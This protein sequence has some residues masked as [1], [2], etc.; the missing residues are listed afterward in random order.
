VST[1]F[2][3]G[4]HNLNIEKIDDNLIKSEIC[5]DILRSLP[6]WFGIEEAIKEYVDGVCDKDFFVAENNGEHIG[7]FAIDYPHKNVANL[8][9]LGINEEYHRKGMGTMLYSHVEDY[10]KS[11]GYSYISVYTLSSKSSYEYYA[12]TREFYR[13]Q[14]FVD[15]YE[16]DKIWDEDNPFLLMIKFVG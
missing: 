13:K 16:S 8:Y 9:V 6:K 11:I 7:F 12:R 5:D 4:E 2:C 1:F 15:A 14:G 10:I 3:I